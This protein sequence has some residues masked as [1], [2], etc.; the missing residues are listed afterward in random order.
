MKSLSFVRSFS[1]CSPKFMM[2][3]KSSLKT[4]PT[5]HSNRIGTLHKT[6]QCDVDSVTKIKFEWVLTFAIARFSEELYAI[7]LPIPQ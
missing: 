3:I 5:T 2:L 6:F 7:L 1:V 4:L